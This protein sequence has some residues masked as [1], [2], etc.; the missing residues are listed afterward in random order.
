MEKTYNPQTIEAKWSQFWQ[1]HN[2]AQPSGEEN[3]YCIVLP[4]P[5]VTG[6]LHMGHG[7][8]HTLMDALIR[9][10]RMLGHK[11]LWQPGTDHA[12]IATQMVVERQLRQQGKNRHDLG[13]DAFID[14]VW[15]W[16]EQSG[17]T[18]T[19]QIRRMGASLDWEREHFSM[20]PSITKA[21]YSAFIQL[22]EEG[23]IY[24]GK[25]L[26]NWD[27]QLN[28]AISDLE[29]ITK[30]QQGHLWHI[31]YP[32]A[33]G[34]DEL[35]IAT[36][37]PETLL[38]DTAVA[39]H[40]DDKRYTHLIGQHIKLPLTEREIPIIADEY[41]D[42]EFGTGCVKITPAHDFNDYEVGQR[43]QLPL[44]NIMTLDA[45][46]NDNVPTCYQGLER[47][48]ARKQILQDL[49]QQG[50][51]FKTEDH[52][53][54]V[55]MGDRSGVV[56]EPLLTDQ[57]FIKM[58]SLAKPAIAALDKKQIRFIPENWSK[59]YR[60]WLEEI[61]DWC[62]SRQLWWGPRI[63]V[64][65]DEQGQH[66]VGFDEADV[67]QRNQLSDDI[68]LT[69]DEDVLD[70]W[71]TASLWPFSS[72]GWPEKTPELSSFYPG[73]V[74]VTGF[75]IIFFWVAR[76]V[77]MGLKLVGDVPFKEIYI[78]G[79]IRDA[80]GQKMSKSKGNVLDPI[81]L[82]D[83]IELDAL[84]EKRT[85]GLMQPDMAPTIAKNTRE[86]FPQGIDAF[87]TDALRFTFCALANTGRNINF[88]FG[89]ITGYRNFCNKL[90]NA[91]RYVFMQTENKP[92]DFAAEHRNV[93]D[94]WIISEL[95]QVIT[96]SNKAFEEYRFDR[97]AQ[98]LYEFVWNEYCD[99]YLELSKCSLFNE[100]ADPAQQ[101]ATRG[102]LLQ[103]LETILRL[104]HPLTP[105]ISEE[106]WQKSN[107]VMRKTES[108]D[109]D[110]L[111]T[112]TY[113]Q[114]DRNQQDSQAEQEIDW[115]KQVVNA[116]RNIR[117][118][119]NITPGKK[120]K[121]LLGKGDANDRKLSEALNT[122]ILSLAKVSELAWL[123]EQ[124]IPPASSTAL[125]GRLEI[126][127]PLADLIDRDAEMERLRKTIDKLRKE[128]QKSQAKL[129]NENYI[130]KAPEAVVTKEREHLQQVDH[131]L[132][133]L[134]DQFDRI[135]N[136]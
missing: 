47:F 110:S 29:V 36:T 108:T 34:D 35:I 7:F 21:T 38:G 99:W 28:T 59:T 71:F 30:E 100:A 117:S 23:L 86:E 32:L 96:K 57:W 44:I 92:L 81:D 114:A 111:M 115:L 39:V 61:Q 67:R 105:F 89:R 118:E 127:I 129:N 116:I 4:P 24:R 19:R 84:I 126:H 93:A 8:Q 52:T 60:N 123:N 87:G 33:S 26:V 77:M 91:A 66:Y 128:Q 12:G 2:L 102:T 75:D 13:R 9:R 131:D 64:W 73:N 42:P 106:I 70:T 109:K 62:I 82:I 1:A 14:K 103:V 124:E 41:V 72:L 15:Q 90:W 88:D 48:A 121:I 119:M 27:P 63:P 45:H 49:E 16:R 43:H 58:E 50:L 79:L 113:P 135:Q 74:L 97:I 120:I 94:R 5:N 104:I 40:P 22:F 76:M 17:S 98:Q 122:Y 85:Q 20:D 132:I 10:Q 101:A 136:L 125:V 53:L 134:Q 25:R 68:V 31:R 56:I 11:V 107:E 46:L 65:Y 51:L 130:K 95:Q 78:T 37:R 18:I 55:P 6:T 80:H 54:S 3:P 112:A 69:Q 83:G 133:K